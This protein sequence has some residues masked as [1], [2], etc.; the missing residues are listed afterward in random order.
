MSLYISLTYL[1][2]IT[3]N[4]FMVKQAKWKRFGDFLRL[5]RKDL[6]LTQ[7]A[8]SEKLAVAQGY[9]TSVERGLVV[10]GPAIME[11]LAQALQVEMGSMY[12][13]LAENTRTIPKSREQL[14]SEWLVRIKDD[15][16]LSPEAKKY[17]MTI[18]QEDL[19][20]E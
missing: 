5:R 19:K 6:G 12:N 9:Y 15:P 20:D 1:R 8:L 11:A 14:R 4:S 17:M 16:Y 18:I 3:Y 10:P 7:T 2:S 13:L